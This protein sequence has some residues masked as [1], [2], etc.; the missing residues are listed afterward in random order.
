MKSQ[1]PTTVP[2]WV[3]LSLLAIAEM[4]ISEE[5]DPREFEATVLARTALGLPEWDEDARLGSDGEEPS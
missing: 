5:E 4:R 1:T 3:L 2:R